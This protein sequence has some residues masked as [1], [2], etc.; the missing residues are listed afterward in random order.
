[1][2]Y[3]FLLALVLVLLAAFVLHRT[4]IRSKSRGQEEVA[5]EFLG[6]KVAANG[7]RAVAVAVAL[8]LGY[9]A[10]KTLSECPTIGEESSIPEVV[11]A[12]AALE[13]AESVQARIYA[14]DDWKVAYD[15]SSQLDTA[16]QEQKR[17]LPFARDWDAV[18]RLA[19][20]VDR[21]ARDTRNAAISGKQSSRLRASQALTEAKGFLSASRSLMNDLLE[22]GRQPKD[23]RK[24]MELMRGIYDGLASQVSGIELSISSERFS[25][26]NAQSQSLAES[27]RTLIDDLDLAMVKISCE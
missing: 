4:Y 6:M 3:C 14:A 15:L 12:Q 2:I 8:G 5:F 25:E 1:M 20:K 22:C 19:K 26:A 10:F 21:A 16:I 17:Q 27:A 9:L 23:F 7:V 11:L 13:E 18:V 24:D